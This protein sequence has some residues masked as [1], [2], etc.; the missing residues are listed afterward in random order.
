MYMNKERRCCEVAK[1][2]KTC[3]GIEKF[4]SKNTDSAR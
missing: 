3:E 1:K 2:D 4:P